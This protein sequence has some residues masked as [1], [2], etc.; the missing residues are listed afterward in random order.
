MV[1]QI[2]AITGDRDV[3]IK[4]VQVA[5]LGA[6]LR[7]RCPHHGRT[8]FHD[9]RLPNDCWTGGG[10]KAAGK[11]ED[12]MSWVV[13]VVGGNVDGART[14]GIGRSHCAREFIHTLLTNKVIY[15]KH[16]LLVQPLNFPF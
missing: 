14:A 6:G 1:S 4:A 9:L 5:T 16:H 2:E 11:Q 15:F 8:H 7:S 3:E 12:A 10:W 13:R